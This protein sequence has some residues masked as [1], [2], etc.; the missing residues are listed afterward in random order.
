MYVPEKEESRKTLWR[1]NKF[2]NFC[3]FFFVVGPN[4][5]PVL[6]LVEQGYSE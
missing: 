4:K 5:V 3:C 1:I 2:H 6:F